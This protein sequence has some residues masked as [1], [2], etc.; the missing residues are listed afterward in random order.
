MG[1]K[2]RKPGRASWRQKHESTSSQSMSP[3]LLSPPPAQLRATSSYQP[4]QDHSGLTIASPSS[5]TTSN[6][7]KGVTRDT[8]LQT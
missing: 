1:G 2:E 3:D 4:D 8:N 6:S 7:V 5:A